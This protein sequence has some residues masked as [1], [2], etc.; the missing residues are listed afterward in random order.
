M[1][2][3]RGSTLRLFDHPYNDTRKNERAVEVAI[4]LRFVFTNCDGARVGLEVGNVLGHYGVTGHTVVDLY[5]RGWPG[6]PHV[7]NVDVLDYDAGPFDWI[8]SISTIEHTDDPLATLAHL[9]SLLAPGGHLLVTFPM[10]AHFDL[11]TAAL[12]DT[13]GFAH[14][15]TFVRDGDGWLESPDIEWR[16]YG[17][18]PGWAGA[19]F[20]GES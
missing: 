6:G 3:Y 7:T 4:A 12:D 20:I 19:V 14:A 17:A 13:L 2:T 18:A 5:E 8:V 9:R 1:F 11:D 15:C 16:P 10:G